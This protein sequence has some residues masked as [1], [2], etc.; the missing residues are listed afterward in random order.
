MFFLT[1]IRCSVAERR[2]VNNLWLLPVVIFAGILSLSAQTFD[3]KAQAIYPVM[4]ITEAKVAFIQPIGKT[5]YIYQRNGGKKAKWT[6]QATVPPNELQTNQ[7]VVWSVWEP[8]TNT[9]VKVEFK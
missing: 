4:M 9:T 3:V 2:R 5:A 1:N 8:K 7:G 6:L